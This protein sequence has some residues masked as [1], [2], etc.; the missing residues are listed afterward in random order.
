[1]KIIVTGG[2][3]FIASHIVDSYIKLGHS[4]VIVDDL[5][6]GKRSFL[7]KRAKFYHQDIGDFKKI[8][9][10]FAKEK[11]DI[12]N[13]HAAQISVRK[14]V[15]DP[16][17][18]A[19]VN[20]IG[21]L[22]ILEAGRKSG[23]KKIIFASSGGVV[24][25]DAKKLPTAESYV[26]LQPSSPYGVSKLTSEYYLNYYHQSTAVDYIALRYSNVY[27]PRQN[28]HG[29]AGVVAIF[30]R[31][32]LRGLVPIVNGDGLQTRDYVYVEDVVA[33][34][35]SALE[36][37]FIGGVNIATGIETNVLQIYEGIEAWVK[38]GIRP[39]HGMAKPGE[40]KRS[41]LDIKLA[42]K[43]LHWKPRYSLTDGLKKT[44]D[45]FRETK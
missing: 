26:P 8:E 13:H 4:V 21:L 17:Y 22:N 14:S 43:V 16:L 27:G 7:N 5:S 37:K 31:K 28:P 12:V 25:G 34:N 18:D 19:Q 45:Y 9:E 10:I 23:V 41:C 1:M 11:P 35:I 20:I 38:S 3:G 6:S 30:S 15:E 42:E 44:V 36:K 29:E 32:L 39:K 24:Y 2:A 40:Q 33:A